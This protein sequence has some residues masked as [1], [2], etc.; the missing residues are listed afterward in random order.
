MPLF[1]GVDLMSFVSVTGLLEC[2]SLF[3]FPLFYV[4][5]R[6]LAVMTIHY[7]IN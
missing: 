3:P 1:N 7:M 4:P 6:F 2:F 5:V